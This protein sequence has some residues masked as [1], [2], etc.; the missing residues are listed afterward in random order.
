MSELSTPAWLVGVAQYLHHIDEPGV[1]VHLDVVSTSSATATVR[2]DREDIDADPA[3]VPA[4][5]R[6]L[7][8]S[9][10][11]E[12]TDSADMTDEE[13]E[14]ELREMFDDIGDIEDIEEESVPPED[15]TVYR[16]ADPHTIE[17][18]FETET[19]SGTI[20]SAQLPQDE[21]G[22][23]VGTGATDPEVETPQADPSVTSGPGR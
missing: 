22:E 15:E 20:T 2:I 6:T 21:E 13:V 4:A 18:T 16:S 3:D 14:E 9:I 10:E 8:S 12:G 17:D 11:Q 7:A 19:A 1:D 5:L 23:S